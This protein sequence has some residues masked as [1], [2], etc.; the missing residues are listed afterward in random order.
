MLFRV[1]AG[2]LG[3]P[4]CYLIHTFIK[5]TLFEDFMGVGQ[6]KSTLIDDFPEVTRKKHPYL[7]K[8]KVLAAS[9]IYLPFSN[10]LGTSMGEQL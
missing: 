9:E 1:D 3:I 8:I 6:Q 7:S 10:I 5:C 4:F 2:L